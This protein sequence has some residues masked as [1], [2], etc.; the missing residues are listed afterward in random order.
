MNVRLAVFIA[1]VLAIA[2]S[3]GQ[4]A[5]TPLVITL[6]DALTRAREHGGQYQAANFALAQAREDTKQAKS[7]RL[8]T[9]NA[10]NQMIYTQG[11]GTSSGVFVAND[12]VHVYN[13]QAVV[14]E[15]LG[16]LLR[17]GETNRAIAAEALARAKAEVASRGL[18]ATVIQ[19]YYAV[20]TAQYHL[21]N[22]KHSVEEAERF[23]DITSKQEK[24]GE[25]AHADVLK[26]QLDLK[27]RQRD[28]KEAQLA[29]DKAKIALGVIIFPN[30][31]TDFSVED[32]LSQPALL[33]P[34][35][36]A[37]AAATASSPDLKSAKAGLQ[38]ASYDVSVA[39]YGFLPSF[40]FDFFY[41]INANQFL[42]RT[43]HAQSEGESLPYRQN[44][45]Y[46]AQATLTIPVWNWGATRSKVKQAESKKQQA[47]LDL[48]LAQRNLLGSVAAA[49]AEA[50]MAQEQLP[51]LKESSDMAVESLRLM[52]LR[53]QA[54]ESTSLE[55]VDAQNTLTQ[56]R[57]AYADG[58]VRY[59]SAWA[60]L[61]TLM[62]NL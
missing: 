35:Q 53:Y 20:L 18:N 7:A 26:G 59:R 28:F 42:A 49:Y 57:N 32:D 5:S 6:K 48:S 40:T 24:R 44:L 23:V 27:Q 41:G 51:S 34:V 11:N 62:G 46:S 15:D 43:Y 17:R 52:L 55:V 19:N 21:A 3:E 39:R 45:G 12:G 61:Q 54:G 22:L 10:L 50:R 16:L 36:E 1:G 47:E 9:V 31:N 29:I 4:T 14:H 25:A 2:H 30:Y 8:P 60:T 33:Q 13:E 58:L 56:A 37:S 38:T